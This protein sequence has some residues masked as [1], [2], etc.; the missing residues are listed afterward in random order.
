MRACWS[1]SLADALLR[2]PDDGWRARNPG[3]VLF[4]AADRFVADKLALVRRAGPAPTP[5]LAVLFEHLDQ[6]GTR[7]TLL[8]ARAGVTGP[9]MTELIARATALGLVERRADPGDARA[10][11]V[12][13]TPDGLVLQQRLRAGVLGAERAMARAVGPLFVG[14]LKGRLADYLAQT[15]PGIAPLAPDNPAWRR[16]SVGRVLPTAARRFAGDTLAVVRAR[17]FASV[18]EGVLGLCRHLDRDGTRLT[19]LATRARMT[20]PAMAELVARAEAI[21]LVDRQPDPR[22]GRAR[23]IRFTPRGDQ[24]L[25]AAHAGVVAAEARLAAAAGA[26]F[27]AELVQRLSAYA[28]SVSPRG[29]A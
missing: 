12:A 29:S 24:L 28:A 3:R 13:F 27:V 11:L 16:R 1:G 6:T 7:P 22:D 23:A 25:D 21:G 8:A 9:S 19:V 15:G 5:A 17:G 4:A 10:R 20:K 26:A 14:L 18:N 2:S